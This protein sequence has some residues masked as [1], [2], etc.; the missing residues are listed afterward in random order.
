MIKLLYYVGNL[1]EAKDFMNSMPIKLVGFVTIVSVLY[2]CIHIGIVKESYQ[3][4]HEWL[5]SYYSHNTILYTCMVM[6]IGHV[7][8]LDE[9]KDFVKSMLIKPYY[10]RVGYYSYFIIYL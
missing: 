5:L 10:C 1:D 3:Y 8:N 7:G 6:F 4:F 2:T 9:V